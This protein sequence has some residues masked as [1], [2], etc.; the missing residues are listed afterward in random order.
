[1]GQVTISVTNV[2]AGYEAV[3]TGTQYG[4][5]V[6]DVWTCGA[7]FPT[8]PTSQLGPCGAKATYTLKND[9]SYIGY[10][11]STQKCPSDAGTDG[12]FAAGTLVTMADGSAKAIETIVAGDEVLSFDTATQVPVRGTVARTYVHAHDSTLLRI[13]DSLV[14]T[15][16]HVF[17][18]AGEWVLARSLRPADPLLMGPQSGKADLFAPTAVTDGVVQSI[19]EMPGG[20]PVYNLETSP[21]HDFFASGVL[22]HN[23][24]TSGQ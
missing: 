21:V 12:C 22:V 9:S 8:K 13:N 16:G 18:R 10:T 1:V 24:S 3:L 20:P 14:T 19:E 5:L 11:V 7:P 4:G 23:T 2:R 15:P 6:N 17:Y